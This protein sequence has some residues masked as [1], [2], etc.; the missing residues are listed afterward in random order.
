MD[1]S[2]RQN[3]YASPQSDTGLVPQS[4]RRFGLI[5]PIHAAGTLTLGDFRRAAMV[6]Q[7]PVPAWLKGFYLVLIVAMPI[8]WLAFTP[9]FGPLKWS[10]VALCGLVA[11]FLL[12]ATLPTRWLSRAKDEDPIEEQQLLL[13]EDGLSAQSADARSL[14]PWSRF[15]HFR[16]DTESML[17]YMADP[18][19]HVVLPRRFF[20]T[21]EEWQAAAA[22]VRFKLP[23]QGTPAASELA[24]R[25]PAPASAKP[26]EEMEPVGEAIAFSGRPT[27]KE[28][29]ALRRFFPYSQFLVRFIT[30]AFLLLPAVIGSFMIINQGPDTRPAIVVGAAAMTVLIFYILILKPLYQRRRD[31]IEGR[32]DYALLSGQIS[33]LGIETSRNG[34]RG[35]A[36]WE[37]FS[38]YRRSKSVVLLLSEHGEHLRTY[39]VFYRSLFS[40]DDAWQRFIE[41]VERRLPPEQRRPWWRRSKK[42]QSIASPQEGR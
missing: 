32:G 5:E 20:A 29:A 42:Q 4:E 36:S 6:G 34:I 12:L 7:K 21:E 8:G 37:A 31:R 23:E 15:T 25:G 28:L 2:I 39:H 35:V 14:R 17:L 19:S 40:S 41:M 38:S 18:E 24:S 10:M 33:E 22:L 11:F 1:D 3:P 26:Q 16:S 9:G 27:A 30:V 13:T